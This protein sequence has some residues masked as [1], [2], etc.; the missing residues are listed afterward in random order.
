M[1]LTVA[2]ARGLAEATMRAVGHDAVDA[3]LIADHLI[4]C[5]LRGIHYGGLARALSIV[6]RL[7]VTDHRGPIAV[8]RDTP[9]LARLDGGDQIGYV[10]AH[11]ATRMAI[12]KARASGLAAVAAHNTWVHRH[13]VLLRRDGGCRRARVDDCIER[14]PWCAA[15]RH[16]GALAPTRSASGS[17]RMRPSSG[18]SAPPP[19][20]TPK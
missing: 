5:E 12:D 14:L 4:D 7:R 16:R 17:Q 2:E 18:T 1:K 13:A 20:S 6:E 19:S 9:V 8:E 3:A 11:R 15:R 10:V